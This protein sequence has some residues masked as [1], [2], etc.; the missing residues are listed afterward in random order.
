[1]TPASMGLPPAAN[2][3]GGSIAVTV[4]EVVARRLYERGMRR[5]DGYPGDGI[6]GVTADLCRLGKVECIQV[7][8]E[9]SAAFAVRAHAKYGGGAPG[10][11]PGHVRAGPVQDVASEYVALASHAAQYAPSDRLDPSAVAAKVAHQD[12]PRIALVGDGA[13]RAAILRHRF[14]DLIQDFVPPPG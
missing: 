10:C 9:E 6:N 3:R 1:M 7:R 2:A 4:D 14:R 8:H 12:G 11:G 13:N 5:I